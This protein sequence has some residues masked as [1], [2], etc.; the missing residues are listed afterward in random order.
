[1]IVTTLSNSLPDYER[2]MLSQYVSG[3]EDALVFANP[4]YMEAF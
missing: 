2:Q 1:M 3:Q 4:K